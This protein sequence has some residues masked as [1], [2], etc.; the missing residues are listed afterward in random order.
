MPYTSEQLQ[1][2]S[3]KFRN[4][5][6]GHMPDAIAV[7]ISLDAL[8]KYERE[9][10]PIRDE[11][12]GE[13][14]EGEPFVVESQ[15]GYFIPAPRDER[16]RAWRGI[17]SRSVIVEHFYVDEE[18]AREDGCRQCERC[19][20]WHHHSDLDD[21]LEIDGD[22]YCSYDCAHEDGWESCV[23][24]GEWV[25]IDDAI[26][27]ESGDYPVFCSSYC[28]E[29]FGWSRCE[30]C[31]E[32][33]DETWTVGGDEWCE[34]CMDYYSSGCDDCGERWP[35]DDIEYDEENDMYLCPDCRGE[36]RH[37]SRANTDCQLHDYGWKPVLEF[38]TLGEWSYYDKKQP[39]FMGVELETDGGEDRSGYV[40][41]LAS[42]PTFGD[43]FW[44]TKDSSLRNG[45]EITGHPMTLEFH[46]D[47][48]EKVYEE[49][50]KAAIEFGY[51][52]HD[53]GRCGLHVHVNRNFFGQDK[54]LQDAGGYKLIRLLQRFEPAF[55]LFSRRTDN[56]WCNYKLATDYAIKDEV[57]ISRAGKDE[58]GSIQK[59]A[60]LTYN[61]RTHAQCLNFQHS[62]TFEFRIFRGTLKWTTYFACLGMVD[63]LC[64]TV[65]KHGSVWVE[66][67]GW[68]DLMDEVIENCSTEYARECLCN[69]LDEKGL[70]L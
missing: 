31:D 35:E 69:Y 43:Y 53:G 1:T 41:R 4:V 37:V 29:Q 62:Q 44:M 36:H 5:F 17:V 7:Q 2:V 12:T 34:H 26:V 39:L 60:S 54:R 19:G 58:G 47:L 64:R 51:R 8:A 22:W 66:N 65:K 56:Y 13:I 59:A 67:V 40:G 16:W 21:D 20:E 32:W 42:I 11:R 57:K 23:R 48:L 61:E 45:V 55:T 68:L 49:I 52:S 28:A 15:L 18:S 27:I 10:C 70:R 30:N 25:H 63:G 38:R 24:C 14:I 3:T 33:T 46:E 50:R 6:R 9:N